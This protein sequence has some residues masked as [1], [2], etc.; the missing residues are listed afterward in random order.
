M[1]K[2]THGAFQVVLVV[3]NCLSMWDTQ[4]TRVWSLGQEDPLEKEVASHSSILTWENPWTEERSRTRLTEQ[5]EFLNLTHIQ[6]SYYWITFYLNPWCPHFPPKLI[7]MQQEC[8]WQ[9]ISLSASGIFFQTTDTPLHYS[10]LIQQSVY[11]LLHR[12]YWAHGTGK[13]H[14]TS[15]TQAVK[16]VHLTSDRLQHQKTKILKLM[17]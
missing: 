6:K 4:E 3:K 10:V 2:G 12:G 8:R 9:S 11:Q 17:T 14:P 7:S 16:N 5:K 13:T 1:A 15:E